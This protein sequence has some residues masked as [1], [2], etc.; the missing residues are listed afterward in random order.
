MSFNEIVF[1]VE[2]QIESP[3]CFGTGHIEE[4]LR[5]KMALKLE[6][7]IFLSLTFILPNFKCSAANIGFAVLCR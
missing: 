1:L 7:S 6:H 5:K 4:V 2:I 3:Y